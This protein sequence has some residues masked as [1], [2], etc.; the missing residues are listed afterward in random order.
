MVRRCKWRR[1]VAFSG[2]EGAPVGGDGECGV[3]QHQ[4]G[5]GV[6]G[7]QEIARIGSSG[8][9]STGSGGW[10]RCSARIREGDWAA[11]G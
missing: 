1:A 3:L 6:R 2:G 5:K 7:L 9:S 4:R 10:Q 8:R 11:G